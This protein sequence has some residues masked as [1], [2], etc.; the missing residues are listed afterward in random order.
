MGKNV[1]IQGVEF[2][3]TLSRVECELWLF[4]FAPQLMKERTWRPKLNHNLFKAHDCPPEKNPKPYQGTGRFEHSQRLAKGIWPES[5]EWH[6]WSTKAVKA[7]CE[8]K[9][10]VVRGCGNSSKSTS[11]G[12]YAWQWFICNPMDSAVLNISTSIDGAKR[13]IWREINRYYQ[14]WVAKVGDWGTRQLESPRPTIFAQEKDGAHICGIIPVGGGQEEE[15]IR[16]L[17]G[18]HPKR[19]L[20]ICDELDSIAQDVVD[21]FTLNLQGG[22]IEAQFIGL[23]NDPS[24]FNPLGKLCDIENAPP[25]S[26]EYETSDGVKVLVFDGFKS[27]NIRDGNKWSGIITKEHIDEVVKRFGMDSRHVDI[28]M[29]GR[30]NPLG[31]A[32]VV[33]PESLFIRFH[34]REKDVLWRDKITKCA[35]LDPAFG[36]DRCVWRPMDYG[37]DI[38]GK[39]KVLYGKEVVIPITA[40]NPDDPA[41]Y[42]IARKVQELNK[43]AGVEPKD[44]ILDC[45]GTGRGAASVL[46]REYSAAIVLCEFG[47]G[48]SEEPVSAT[49]PKRCC[50]EYERKVAELYFTMREFVEADMVRGLDLETCREFSGRTFST[51]N[52]RFSVQTKVEYKADGHPSPDLADNAVLGPALLKHHHVLPHFKTSIPAKRQ[53]DWGKVCARFDIDAREDCYAEP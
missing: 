8:N 50:D 42:Q 7:F 19:I 24:P 17:K 36:G 37:Y 43:S 29:R 52:K 35:L 26:E 4:R 20:M 34:A 27:P 30:Y 40:K 39:M 33:I 45:T 53:A 16:T 3:S 13:R 15:G 38:H 2:P 51:K 18:F 23:G 9:R 31:A 14:E 28:F 11:A 21:I 12:M 41:E 1:I 25:N 32:D 44:F 6:D 5:F 46:L 10:T 22:T 47:G 49:N 48:A